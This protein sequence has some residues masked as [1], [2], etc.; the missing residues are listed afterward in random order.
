MANELKFIERQE[1]TSEETME[2]LLI[3]K[4]WDILWLQNKVFSS[5]L[6]FAK[7]ENVLKN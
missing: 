6:A 5:F 1:I 7:G 3:H 2:F 4:F